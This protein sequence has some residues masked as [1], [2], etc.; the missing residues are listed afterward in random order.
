MSRRN[1][2]G[3]VPSLPHN[4]PRPPL[5]E[6]L[7]AFLD[8]LSAFFSFL[9]FAGFFLSS[10]FVSIALLMTVAPFAQGKCR[11]A[12]STPTNPRQPSHAL[13]SAKRRKERHYLFAQHSLPGPEISIFIQ[14]AYP[15]NKRRIILGHCSHRLTTC[16]GLAFSPRPF[17]SR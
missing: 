10:F 3:A 16:T 17:F 7:P 15:F 5:Q 11:A 4:A 14:K 2:A 8:F 6:P 9:L 12:S 1:L 13:L